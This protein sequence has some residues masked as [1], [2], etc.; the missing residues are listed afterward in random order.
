MS[1]VRTGGRRPR[2][3]FVI[4]SIGSGGA[5]RALDTILRAG[6]ER[7][8][9][10]EIHL[11]LLDREPEMRA[12]PALHGR[13]CLDAKGGLFASVHGLRRLLRRLEPDL[14]VGFLARANVAVA[15]SGGRW[16]R[17]LCERMHMR[18]HL[19]GRHR[20][21][22]LALMHRMLRAAYA[23]ATRVLGVSRGVSE[24]LIATFGAPAARVRTINNPYD[25]DRIA[26]EA[27]APPGIALP[28]AYLLA[29]GR[30][31]AAKGFPDLVAAYARAAPALPLVILGEGEARAALTAQIA[32]AGLEGR[33]LLPGFVADPYAVMGRATALV[34]AS[35]NE[36]FPNAIAE[37]MALGLPVLAT[38]CP[39]GPAEL[40]GAPAGASGSVVEAPAG[41]MVPMGDVAALARGLGML[42]DA[43]L[44]ARIGAH[45]RR[46]MQDFTVERIA[47][48]YWAVFDAAAAAG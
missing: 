13:H 43:A 5:E 36:G 28:P 42:E 2:I 39:S 34:S 45:A 29:V 40:L 21:W 44:R 4:N 17:I 48:Q 1:A 9:C 47:G 20:G 24:D 10:Y 31:V 12:L 8:E 23:R 33:V 26:A 32:A 7:L 35:H 25:L 19:A 27:A 6:G 38:D 41:L 14:V 3:V 46:R 16:R 18:S 22:R 37:A 30:L 15:F 11:V